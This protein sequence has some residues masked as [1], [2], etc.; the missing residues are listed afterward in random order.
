[1]PDAPSRGYD[2]GLYIQPL[3]TRLAPTDTDRDNLPELTLPHAAEA[4]VIERGHVMWLVLLDAQATWITKDTSQLWG[5]ALIGRDG[6]DGARWNPE[7]PGHLDP[8]CLIH[9]VEDAE[10]ILFAWT[11]LIDLA[12]QAPKAPQR[13]ATKRQPPRSVHDACSYACDCAS[14]SRAFISTQESKVAR[15]PS[16]NVD[17]EV[18]R[19]IEA[20]ARDGESVN[21]SLRRLL[22]LPPAT[23]TG[24]GT[25]PQAAGELAALIAAGLIA[26]GE[27]V[28]ATDPV[29]VPD[30]VATVAE[31][32]RLRAAD[33]TIYPGPRQLSGALRGATFA[34]YGWQG[35][36]AADGTRL[37]TLRQRLLAETAPHLLPSGPGALTPMIAAGLLAPG[38]ELRLPMHR[39]PGGRGS[40]P[41]AVGIATVTDDGCFLLPD[42]DRYLTPTAASA[43]YRGNPFNAWGSWTAPDGR[44]LTALRQLARDDARNR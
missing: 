41:I 44:R 3:P 19:A 9:T 4:V 10:A 2:Q 30:P 27:P 7:S 6:R 13:P 34:S 16:V 1:M 15:M 12:N 22:G 23:G 25:G 39:H 40:L 32:G 11:L 26:L 37:E 24:T 31:Y 5:T 33:G 36:T 18:Y 29:P 35:L 38:D 42:G 43:A 17:D 21:Q 20:A 14:T 8:T 28:Y